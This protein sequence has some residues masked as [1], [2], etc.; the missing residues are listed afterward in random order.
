MLQFFGPFWNTH[1]Q[2]CSRNSHDGSLFSPDKRFSFSPRF[3]R[4][5]ICWFTFAHM[6]QENSQVKKSL[7]FKFSEKLGYVTQT[8]NS[9]KQW[10]RDRWKGNQ[11]DASGPAKDRTSSIKPFVTQ[12][13]PGGKARPSLAWP[14]PDR[15]GQQPGSPKGS[16]TYLD[17]C[18]PS[19]R[20]S[21]TRKSEK[22]EWDWIKRLS[23]H[24]AHMAHCVSD[25]SCG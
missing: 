4:V 23:N 8:R 21:G 18:R 9:G 19:P 16:R 5:V 10:S 12:K 15:T 22:S 17:L 20:S 25:L 3:V 1:V 2:Y 13:R 7:C 6:L 14:V 11:P 24:G